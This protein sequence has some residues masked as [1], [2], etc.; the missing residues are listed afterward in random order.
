MTPGGTGRPDAE[1]GGHAAPPR[2]ASR[3][4]SLASLA[5]IFAPLA[6]GIA[7]ARV[8]GMD[9]LALLGVLVSF[10][11]ACA[12]IWLRRER[13]LDWGLGPL[14][15][16]AVSIALLSAPALL[17]VSSAA[18]ALLERWTGWTPNAEAFDAVR[19]NVPVLLSGLVLVWT[20]A[21]FGEEMLFRGVLLRGLETIF[22]RRGLSGSGSA[23]SALLISSILFGLAHEYQGAAGMVLTGLV[24]LA[25]GLLVLATRNLWVAIL[26]HGVYDT[27]AFLLVFS[28]QDRLLSPDWVFPVR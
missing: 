10:V 24:G 5:A 4:V 6:A 28:G 25:H 7:L 15:A 13:W 26:T 14:D 19:G 18:G 22:V 9:P 23:L 8:H 11:A 1:D 27:I 17:M 12:W 21:A 16:R 3:P 2:V 20:T